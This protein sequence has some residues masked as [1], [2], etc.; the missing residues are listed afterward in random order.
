MIECDRIKI[1]KRGGELVKKSK[2]FT[3]IMLVMVVVIGGFITKSLAED[4]PKVF[5]V[6]DH[7]NIEYWKTIKAGA[8]KGFR[9][10]G[11]EGK[12][13]AGKNG[14]DEELINIL[15][16]IQKQKPDALI[17]AG[18][19]VE[20]VPEL[21]KFV[22]KDIPVLLVSTDLPWANKTSYIG[23]NNVDLGETAGSFLASQLQPGDH[24]A[25]IGGDPTFSVFNDRIKGYKSTL[26]A[27]GIHIAVEAF[28]ISDDEETIKNTTLEM[29]DKHPE[30]KGIIATHD[31]MA[32]QVLT[33]IKKQGYDIPVI[34]ADGSSDMVELILKGKIPGTVAQNPYDMGYLS[35]ETASKV[36]KGEK[37]DTFI[38][39]GVD[40]IVESNAEDRHEF[41]K[42]LFQ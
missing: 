26:K 8:E 11:I 32:L 13:L 27:A 12:V 4:K 6:L 10:F 18:Q 17:V 21:E 9:D 35:V 40:I 31:T 23:T 24:V 19:S 15:K 3:L 42:K 28:G 34:G 30:V 39:S 37:V 1:V 20:L 2:A 22:N 16:N 25:L 7:F 14:T 5:V 41:L 33:E 29:L 36:T 38:D